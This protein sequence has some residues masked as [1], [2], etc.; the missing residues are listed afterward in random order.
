M[1]GLVV[2]AVA[3]A[4]MIGLLASPASADPPVRSGPGMDD[5][6]PH[7]VRTPAG[8]VDIDAVYFTPTDHGLHRG[9]NASGPDRGPW[10]G[11]CT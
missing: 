5:S 10:H 6:H 3:K 2:L 11:P 1:R 9:G 7:H 8:C 4:L